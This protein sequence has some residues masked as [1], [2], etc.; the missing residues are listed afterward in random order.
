[1]EK[2]N[3]ARRAAFAF[4]GSSGTTPGIGF[5]AMPTLQYR[6]AQRFTRFEVLDWVRE[7]E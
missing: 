6:M 7:G 4:G 5:G 2:K 1:M 3:A